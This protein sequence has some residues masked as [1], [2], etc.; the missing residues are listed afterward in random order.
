MV[1][2]EYYFYDGDSDG[3]TW[4]Y[5]FEP[6]E[7]GEGTTS[8][9]AMK[10]HGEDSNF[11][12]TGISS[13]T[14]GALATRVATP[15]EKAHLDACIKAEKYVAAPE[16]KGPFKLGDTV[17]YMGE[18]C[19]VVAIKISNP[20]N[21]VVLY[22]RGWEMYDGSINKPNYIMDEVKYPCHGKMAHHAT[23]SNAT[24]VENAATPKYATNLERARAEYPI[25]TVI[26][27]ASTGRQYTTNIEAKDYSC[28]DTRIAGCE[29]GGWIYYNGTWA[30]IVSE[31]V[32]KKDHVVRAGE[33]RLQAA[34][35]LYPVGTRI[36]TDSG[37]ETT[38]TVTP[39]IYSTGSG[40]IAGRNSGD[41]GGIWCEKYGWSQI[42]EETASDTY[43][44]EEAEELVAE[45]ARKYPSGTE[46]NPLERSIEKA[47]SHGRASGTMGCLDKDEF[48]IEVGYGW[49]F[50]PEGWADIIEDV[51]T[52]EEI[53]QERLKQQEIDVKAKYPDECKITCAYIDTDI[54]T[55]NHAAYNVMGTGNIEMG[56][57]YI[58]HGDTWA[59]RVFKGDYFEKGQ[60]I[61]L[62]TDEYNYH[63]K[64]HIFK[65]EMDS[66]YFRSEK[67]NDGDSGELKSL[68]RADSEGTEWR[69]ATAEE[70]TLYDDF[71][72]T[73]TPNAKHVG[74]QKFL[75]E[76]IRKYPIGCYYRS[77][78]NSMLIAQCN[79]APSM[80]SDGDIDCGE[81][82]IRRDEKWA[83][84][85]PVEDLIPEGACIVILQEFGG[86]KVGDIRKQKR[87][88]DNLLLYG[89]DYSPMKGVYKVSNKD[90]AWRYA[91][92]KE[93]EL[94]Q[95]KDITN[96]NT[97][98]TMEKLLAAAEE[99]YPVGTE[100]YCAEF[101]DAD[102]ENGTIL[103]KEQR[104]SKL[105]YNAQ[106][107]TLTDGCGG[108]V[109]FKGKWAILKT[110]KRLENESLVQAVKITGYQE[111]KSARDS[112][113]IKASKQDS[114]LVLTAP[115][116]VVER[117]AVKENIFNT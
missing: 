98:D 115:I 87:I 76:A 24:V 93:K 25:G 19:L 49:V 109:Y 91:T 73:G 95:D 66:M 90:I 86:L 56:S 89:V 1:E 23:A 50:G 51:K 65:C 2:G 112:E 104:K 82:W 57:G 41:G 64:N 16:L 78:S 14:S 97:I 45:A 42:L 105:N 21:I 88:F 11:Y 75:E 80:D 94:L 6:E 31:P 83:D 39:W 4:V 96:I 85:I 103:N 3:I 71:D 111:Y 29:S 60:Y 34:I 32:M 58:K 55:V 10:L 101:S 22:S 47:E 40:G 52:P 28:N 5:I 13:I 46:Y 20:K 107:D 37:E 70:I 12:D 68:R 18:H 35:R 54:E 100:Y 81:G 59:K 69:F 8:K 36:I 99:Y 92:S 74:N 117:K 44:I 30:D 113:I 15:A 110:G 43:T 17:K 72:E 9:Y 84:K 53:E 63:S 102:I 7:E 116:P 26:K 61:V 38:I 108:Y 67:D 62:L 79:R 33:T 48:K 106:R 77:A 114:D 27:D